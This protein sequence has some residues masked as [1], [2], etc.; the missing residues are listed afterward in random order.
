MGFSSKNTGVGCHFLL[1]GISWPRDRTRISCIAGRLFTT[2]PLLYWR[3]T[4]WKNGDTEQRRIQEPGFFFRTVWIIRL[5]PPYIHLVLQPFSA[6]ILDKALLEAV[7]FQ[8]SSCHSDC[9]SCRL[10]SWNQSTHRL[11]LWFLRTSPNH[12]LR[13]DSSTLAGN[14][15]RGSLKATILLPKQNNPTKP[16][17]GHLNPVYW[18]VMAT[19]QEPNAKTRI[20]SHKWSGAQGRAAVLRVEFPRSPLNCGVL[21]RDIFF[22]FLILIIFEKSDFLDLPNVSAHV[23]ARRRWF[24]CFYGWKSLGQSLSRPSLARLVFQ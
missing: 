22:F 19:I 20:N 13:K 4:K 11:H 8:N 10:F 3:E 24:V 1:Q 6:S 12:S 2:E 21:S 14:F 23:L 18:V 17:S 16:L 5:T 9:D 15:S 7:T